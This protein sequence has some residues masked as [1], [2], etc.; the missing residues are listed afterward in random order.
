M[1]PQYQRRMDTP[2]PEVLANE[3][4]VSYMRSR[5]AICVRKMLPN[6][7]VLFVHSNRTQ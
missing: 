5:D 7:V 2:R 3:D 6:D 1:V 4:S